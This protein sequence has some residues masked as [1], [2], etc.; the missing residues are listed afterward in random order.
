VWIEKHRRTWRIRDLVAD[1]ATGRQTKITLKS[2]YTTKTAAKD[3]MA[4]L[5][6]EEIT[7]GP[8]VPRG[9]ERTVG[10][11]CQEWWAEYEPTLTRVKSR[12]SIRGVMNR[13]VVRLLGHAT[14][15]QLEDNPAIVQRW[16]ND[17]S[18]GRHRTPARPLAP[19]TVNNA[20]GQLSQIMGYAVKRRLIRANPCT[21][22]DLV[23]PV[24]TEH[25]YVTPAEADQLIAALP[26]HYRPLVLFMLA[27][28]CRWS[29]ALGVRARN[30]DV[31]GRRVRFLK[32]WIEDES[33]HFH[34]E[35]VKSRRGRR[36]VTFTR[37]VA[38]ALAP[39][40]MVDGD[41]DRHV[42]VT[43]RGLDRV[44]HKDFYAVWYPAR[45][46]CGLKGLRVH[47]L[48]HTHVAWLIAG[49]VQ[50]PAISRRLGHKSA[51]FTDDI[52]GHLMEEVDERL[53]AALDEAMTVIDMG[54]NGGKRGRVES[55][56]PGSDRVHPLLRAGDN[57]P[58]WGSE[59]VR[60][61]YP[62][63]DR[64]PNRRR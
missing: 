4:T 34:E 9:A 12:E 54:G 38:E 37:R 45:D 43:P 2:G 16:L 5:R 42:F 39:L 32:K 63:L 6:A 36:T 48:R 58:T 61:S 14:L 47:D 60:I 53:L 62:P 17:L 20:H 8:L 23:D 51:A 22:T 59:R 40:M 27:T 50:M 11:L 7:A 21:E 41:R 13:Y 44:R 10:T 28:G 35:D 18:A 15:R 64:K 55:G 25:M 26:E 19:K 31:L 24:Y 57:T 33:G 1:P 49:G 52:Y 3:A 29:E 30:L 46:A 56:Q